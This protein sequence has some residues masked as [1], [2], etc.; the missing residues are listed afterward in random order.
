MRATTRILFAC[1]VFLSLQ[2]T[3]QSGSEIFRGIG[4]RKDPSSFEIPRFQQVNSGLYRGGR[5]QPG[6]H[7][8]ILKARGVKTIINLEN[9]AQQATWDQ[10]E[11][12]KVGIDFYSEPMTA[13]RRPDDK[14]VQRILTA[15]TNSQ[16]HPIFIHCKHGKD[17]TGLIIGLY[18]VFVDKW[19]AQKAYQ[20]MLQIGFDPRFAALDKYF[21]DKTGMR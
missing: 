8:K 17:R 12:Q 9:D 20:E 13:F 21:K 14:Q 3:A 10:K 19:P 4:Q 15:L 18:R 6:D 16:Y 1:T 11:A 7:L 5:P 2:S